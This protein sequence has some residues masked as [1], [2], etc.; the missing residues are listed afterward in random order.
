MF[1]PDPVVMRGIIR[2]SVYHCA[3]VFKLLIVAVTVLGINFLTSQRSEAQSD[4]TSSLGVGNVPNYP[5][6]TRIYPN[7]VI[8]KP[9]GSAISPATTINNGNGTTTY[10]Y[11]DGTR[12]NTNSNTVSPAGT[13]LTPGSSNGGLNPAQEPANG[14]L[15]LTPGNSNGGLNNR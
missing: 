10:Y 11:L 8:N 2:Y 15:L 9:N 7:G 13:F 1:K 6:G 5:I 12:I 4:S 3:K 14:G